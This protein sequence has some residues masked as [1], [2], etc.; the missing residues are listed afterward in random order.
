[1]IGGIFEMKSTLYDISP[2]LRLPKE[3]Q[4][5]R[6]RRVIQ[7]ELTPRQQQTLLAYYIHGLTI[8]QIAQ[9]QGVQKSTVWRSLKRAEDRIR[10]CLKY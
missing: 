4:I 10:R 1:M 2:G 5:L 3:Q 7:Q 6:L 8:S 9:E